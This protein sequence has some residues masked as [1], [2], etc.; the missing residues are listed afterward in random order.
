MLEERRENAKEIDRAQPEPHELG[1]P[2]VKRFL[3]A[4][5]LCTISAL[6]AWGQ[7]APSAGYWWNPAAAG[8][9]F[10][11]EV[12]N[13]QMFMAGFLYAP[14]GEATWVSSFGPMTSSTQYSGPL[15]TFSGGQTLTG[16][17]IAPVQNSS[18]PGNIAI[19]FTDNAHASVAWPG[20]I[21]PIQRLDFGPGG[22]SATEPATNPETGWWYNPEEGGRGFAVEVQNGS[23]YLAGYMYDPNGNPVWYLANG[24]MGTT[25]LFQGTWVQFANGPTLTGAYK[26][27]NLA[28]GTVGSVT[29]QFLSPSNATMTLPDGRQIPLSRY[30][31]GASASPLTSTM[32]SVDS[33]F[34]V[35]AASAVA[36]VVSPIGSS[37]LGSSL[38]ISTTGLVGESLVLGLTNSGEIFL[39][40][41]TLSPATVLSAD[42][43]ALALTRIFIGATSRTGLTTGQLDTA[44]RTAAEYPNLVT[45]IGSAVNA[46]V[47]PAQSSA[48]AI[49][50]STVLS[51]VAPTLS[52]LRASNSSALSFRQKQSA[53]VF[54]QITTPLPFNVIPDTVLGSLP[55]GI[56]GT[57]GKSFLACQGNYTDTNAIGVVNNMPISWSVTTFDPTTGNPLS[58]P[59][60][61]PSN[62]SMFGAIITAVT[63]WNISRPY[64]VSGNGGKS[65]NLQIGQ[66]IDS[67]VDTATE[68]ILSLI[69]LELE[70][71]PNTC[72]D[73]ALKPAISGIVA[74]VLK[75]TSNLSSTLDPLTAEQTLLA[76]FF[77]PTNIASIVNS[78]ASKPLLGSELGALA[79]LL[80]G[81]ALGST[82]KSGGAL[83][84]QFS[85]AA[86]YWDYQ[87]LLIGVCVSKTGVIDNC[88]KSF[89]FTPNSVAWVAPGVVV[90][91]QTSLSALDAASAQTGVPSGLIWTQNDKGAVLTLDPV[92][93]NVTAKAAGSAAITVTD[94]LTNA[95]GTY[96]VGVTDPVLCP[97][98]A[99]IQVGA[100]QVFTLTNGSNANCA[101]SPVLPAPGT[102]FTSGNTSVASLNVA[103]NLLTSC[104]TQPGSCAVLTGVSPGTTMLSVTNGVTGAV[105]TAAV[106][107]VGGSAKPISIKI[108]APAPSIVQ[109]SSMQLIATETDANGN[110]VVPGQLAWTSNNLNNITVSS[111]GQATAT[112]TA[113]G[114]AVI[115]VTDT[116][117]KVT[118]SVTLYVTPACYLHVPSS[119][120]GNLEVIGPDNKTWYPGTYSVSI[121]SPSCVQKTDS[122]P[123]TVSAS[124]SATLSGPP[125]GSFSMSSSDGAG[126]NITNT[127]TYG[128]CFVVNIMTPRGVLPAMSLSLNFGGDC[129]QYIGI[130]EGYIYNGVALS[131][132]VN[133]TTEN[134]VY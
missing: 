83:A 93:G 103:T 55:V 100:N 32:V 109:G 61:I 1:G 22:A 73:N 78:C 86:K 89:V 70:A 52:S 85:Y 69:D 53:I 97:N 82:L 37:S 65:L 114:G 72:T 33:T 3:L 128:V 47:P 96:G 59:Q 29:V 56:T 117:A 2:A 108:S 80:A 11:I 105:A 101:G 75:G 62:R 74:G 88:D 24:P 95:T 126:G 39:A 98:P 4:V 36:Q 125:G 63:G 34:P 129:D 81:S 35:A 51:Q 77:T 132:I 12:Q 119:V 118:T 104:P 102:V 66:T 49:S 31:F 134:I 13:S 48:V 84:Y 26:V 50:L 121:Q 90:S 27:P 23:M 43:T 30:Y 120:S 110:S 115:T 10:V 131:P 94:P 19:S 57:C 41:L 91:A 122:F 79:K 46:G 112:S 111:T 21:I 116:V 38:P 123:I 54:P 133:A 92:S 60:L 7:T 14:S 87:P 130:N 127:S 28:N 106:T 5:L 45:N 44:I 17:Y 8:S 76:T 15:I 99:T 124:G 71:L 25:V 6:P 113:V 107:V 68:L 42:S 20:G 18:S 64:G 9:G 40:S 58:L 16:T 67:Q